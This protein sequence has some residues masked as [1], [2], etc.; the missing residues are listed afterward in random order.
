MRLITPGRFPAMCRRPAGSA[1]GRPQPAAERPR[2]AAL[3]PRADARDVPH[4]LP[5]G[6][7]APPS[8]GRRCVAAAPHALPTPTRRSPSLH[9][10]PL[11]SGGA[12]TPWSAQLGGRCT[13]SSK[14]SVATSASS[15]ASAPSPPPTP[16]LAATP[17]TA[18]VCGHGAGVAHS[19]A[20]ACLWLPRVVCVR[21]AARLTAMHLAFAR[22]RSSTLA[23]TRQSRSG[24]PVRPWSRTAVFT[25]TTSLDRT[26]AKVRTKRRPDLGPPCPSPCPPPRPSY[27][28]PH[29]RPLAR[30][31][32]RPIPVPSPVLYRVLY[33]APYPPRADHVFASAEPL[34]TSL[35]DG[36]NVCVMAYGRTAAGKTYTL[37]GPHAT[38]SAPAAPTAAPS[39]SSP[40]AA[41]APTS[42][43]DSQRG[44][45]PRSIQRLFQQ[46]RAMLDT[47][48]FKVSVRPPVFFFK[49]APGPLS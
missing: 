32:L 40:A 5:R 9:A 37:M 47:H 10:R 17:T 18:Y 4:R 20:Y 44:L 45:I 15:A 39:S 38:G 26:P 31:I 35:L 6:A 49:C 43:R 48:S 46:M 30:L 7:G 8:G 24:P 3:C 13:T 42:T 2:D 41:V 19:L 33:R 36:Y 16:S 23:T 21:V 12:S 14:S 29:T 25:L 28:A 27:T 22:P 11:Q 34:V 1:H